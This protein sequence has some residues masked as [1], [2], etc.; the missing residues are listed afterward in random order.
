MTTVDSLASIDMEGRMIA[1]ERL[2]DFMP[3]PLTDAQ[4]A[5]EGEE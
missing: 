3:K 1:K 2:L 4:D 5:R